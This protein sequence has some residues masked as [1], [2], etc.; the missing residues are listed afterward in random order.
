MVSADT[1]RHC[2]APL[3]APL[4]A[5]GVCGAAGC[6]HREDRARWARL[7]QHIGEPVL[8]AAARQPDG[9]QAMLLWL[10]VTPTRQR[11]VPKATRAEHRAHL[12]AL[13]EQAA[14][15]AARE[16]ALQPLAEPAP[17]AALG[18]QEWRLCAQ[19]HG[20]CCAHGGPSHAFITL[21]QLLRRQQR[22]PGRTLADAVDWYMAMIAPRHVQGSC[23]Y[24]GP[25]G[26]VLPRQDRADICNS[27]ACEPLA[28]LQQ[29]L[30]DD[31]QAAFV[32]VTLDG[33]RPLRR[34]LITGADTLP[35]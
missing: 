9:G 10:R 6:R 3:P 28:Q 29:K 12:L 17:A 27:Y 15:D 20:R 32:T 13:L 26:C 16:A 31:P 8:Q 24:H 21:P 1:C 18:E 33:E 23:V 34:A 7:S 25:Q 14:P 11:L 4:R 35:L 5:G 22:E 2:A 19:C 30:Q